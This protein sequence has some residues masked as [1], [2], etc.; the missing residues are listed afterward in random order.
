M[1]RT[2]TVLL[3]SALALTV[4]AGTQVALYHH[5]HSA[6]STSAVRASWT[7]TPHTSAEVRARAQSIVLGRI[8][9]VTAGPDIVTAQP[10]EPGGLDRIPTRRVSVTVLTSYKGAAAAGQHLTLFQTGGTASQ[11]AA[12]AKGSGAGQSNVQQVV[13]EGDPDYRAG[14]QY[15]LMLEAGPQAT[16]R[17]VSPE[18]RYLIDSRTGALT[19]MV[20]NEVTQQLAAQQL[21]ALEPTLRAS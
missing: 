14:E 11:P 17:P 2:T 20:R 9:T 1:T 7:F 16:L 10:G 3:G 19:P 4:G 15:L 5:N 13:L 6:S 21:A 8:D 12:P 18:G